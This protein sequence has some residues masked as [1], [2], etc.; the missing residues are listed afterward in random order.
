M[1][2]LRIIVLA[3]TVMFCTAVTTTQATVHTHGTNMIHVIEKQL[4]ANQSDAGF[5]ENTG[6]GGSGWVCLHQNGSYW[7]DVTDY[8]IFDPSQHDE[9]VAWCAAHGYSW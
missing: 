7:A 3:I 4:D 8:T 1:A 9:A 6:Q 2:K 5:L